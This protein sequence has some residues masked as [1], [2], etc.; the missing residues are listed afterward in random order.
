[1]SSIIEKMAWVTITCVPAAYVAIHSGNFSGV[2]SW[3]NQSPI[4]FFGLCLV[5]VFALAAFWALIEIRIRKAILVS[6]VSSK[7]LVL[8]ATRG[9]FQGKVKSEYSS[10]KFTFSIGSYPD[11][12]FSVTVREKALREELD[13][14]GEELREVG[15][16]ATKRVTLEVVVVFILLEV[17][18]NV[19]K[20][21]RARGHYLTEL[22]SMKQELDKRITKAK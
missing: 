6:R 17:A 3:I 14:L 16:Q 5:A 2:V 13:R 19:P 12:V 1:M 21:S 18:K 11:P 10:G 22:E 4:P 7:G 20:G 8:N 15:K 9:K